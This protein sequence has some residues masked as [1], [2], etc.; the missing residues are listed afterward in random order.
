M[1]SIN[2][3]L[4]TIF[5]TTVPV[6]MHNI[7][8]TRAQCYQSE[9]TEYKDFLE[10]SFAGSHNSTNPLVNVHLPSKPNTIIYNLKQKLKEPDLKTFLRLQKSNWDHD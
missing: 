4:M 6:T 10:S 2:V 5:V 1:Y 3:L 7:I 9:I 8:N